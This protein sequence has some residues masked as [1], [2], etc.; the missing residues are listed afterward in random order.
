MVVIIT[1]SEYFI[2]K[3]IDYF[4]QFMVYLIQHFPILFF[5]VVVIEKKK[6]MCSFYDAGAYKEFGMFQKEFLVSSFEECLELASVYAFGLGLLL[7]AVYELVWE[8]K[9]D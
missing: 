3:P 2:S 8:E 9:N 7:V 5:E 4:V 1:V 6:F